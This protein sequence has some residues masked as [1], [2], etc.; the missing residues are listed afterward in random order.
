MVDARNGFFKL[1]ARTTLAKGDGTATVFSAAAA[2]ENNTSAVQV[3]L[4]DGGKLFFMFFEI[5]PKEEFIVVRSEKRLCSSKRGFLKPSSIIR[6]FKGYI[7]SDT[8]VYNM[9]QPVFH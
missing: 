3:D 5:V 9:P 1:Q 8:Y 4:E 6:I 7:Q 2:K